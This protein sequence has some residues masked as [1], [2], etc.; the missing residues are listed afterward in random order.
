MNA[1]DY[2]QAVVELMAKNI[3]LSKGGCI[4]F[5]EADRPVLDYRES[6]SDEHSVKVPVA[7]VSFRPGW[8]KNSPYYA[9]LPDGVLCAID[10]EDENVLWAYIVERYPSPGRVVV[11]E[12]EL[13]RRLDL[14][15]HNLSFI[16]AHGDLKEY[17]FELVD[18]IEPFFSKKRVCPDGT[19]I[20]MPGDTVSGTYYGGAVSF[21]HGVIES[22]L[23][24]CGK[25]SVCTNP[26]GSPWAHVNEQKE[27]VVR[28]DG[29]PYFG[30]TPDQ[31]EYVG[32]D[33]SVFKEWGSAGICG[34]GAVYFPIKVNAWRL[35]EGVD[36]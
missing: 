27:L 3:I 23:T 16:S 4:H 24:G 22:G 15:L 18:F 9:F 35:K 13:S 2:P 32:E 30:Y 28:S 12:K 11:D 6:P 34:N 14:R 36:E 8:V 7:G 10:K 5:P 19:P 20:P 25:L 17:D 29:G 21:G 31:L 1:K 33:V 26:Y